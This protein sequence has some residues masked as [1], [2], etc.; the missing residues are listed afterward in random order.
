MPRKPDWRCR[1]C[2][3]EFSGR[4]GVK[5][6]NT[7]ETRFF[8]QSTVL[9][10]VIIKLQ[11]ALF[12]IMSFVNKPVENSGKHQDG[13]TRLAGTEAATVVGRVNLSCGHSTG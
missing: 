4:T 13:F 11:D 6:K 2:A 3:R 5:S 12:A 7:L 8:I 1:P 10:R 9:L